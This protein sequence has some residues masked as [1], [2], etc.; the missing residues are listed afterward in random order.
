[1]NC[2]PSEQSQGANV[3]PTYEAAPH[4]FFIPGRVESESPNSTSLAKTPHRLTEQANR[5]VIPARGGSEAERVPRNSRFRRIGD[6]AKEYTT[7]FRAI[8]VIFH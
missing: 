6:V 7:V 3:G 1:M 8:N 5:R 2:I 4:L